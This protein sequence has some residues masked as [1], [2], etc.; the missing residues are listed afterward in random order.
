MSCERFEDRV[1][2]VTGSTHGIGLGIAK[3]LSSEGAAVVV[4]DEGAYDGDRIA[5][6]V[7]EG[8]A[9]YLEADVT[10]REEIE[11]LVD[12]TVE[13]YGRIDVLVNNVGDHRSGL[14]TEVTVED[15]EFTFDATLKS[16]WLVTRRAIAEMPEGS[17]VVNVSSMEAIGTVPQMFPYN[18]AKTGLNGLT[19]AMAVELGPVGIRANAVMPG[20]IYLEDPDDD[21]LEQDQKVDPL[22]R[23]GRPADV[24]PLVAFLASDDARYVTGAAV[25]VDGGR[26]AVL[27]NGQMFSK[28]TSRAELG[29]EEADDG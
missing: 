1:A 10:D 11:R 5:E 26:S 8:E 17:S 9:T 25:P 4:N 21:E 20:A 3:R 14:L 15:W 6:E 29:V 27:S 2:L 22:G 28:R 12:R 19:R 16:A 13:T 24:A 23:W 7:L 18:V